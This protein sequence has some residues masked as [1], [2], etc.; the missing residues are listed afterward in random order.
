MHR[1]F[2]SRNLMVTSEKNPGVLDYQDAII[3]PYYL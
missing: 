3:G 2:H 1:D